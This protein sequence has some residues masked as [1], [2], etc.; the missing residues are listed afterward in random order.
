MASIDGELI[1]LGSLLAALYRGVF[2][3]AVRLRRRLR[4]RGNALRHAVSGRRVSSWRLLHCSWGQRAIREVVGPV[5]GIY[6]SRASR[7]ARHYLGHGHG[8]RRHPEAARALNRSGYEV[9]GHERIQRQVESVSVKTLRS[10]SRTTA[11]IQSQS[12]VRARRESSAEFRRSLSPISFAVRDAPTFDRLQTS[13][14]AFG[15]VRFSFVAFRATEDP[16]FDI[17]LLTCEP[18]EDLGLM[19]IGSR[20]RSLLLFLLALYLLWYRCI[21]THLDH[22]IHVFR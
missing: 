1:L 16:L 6:A 18:A 4:S 7:N 14:L 3:T 17:R 11:A 13:L 22:T 20:I 15:V 9:F 12:R 8:M 21:A 19:L 10:K 2:S 5:S